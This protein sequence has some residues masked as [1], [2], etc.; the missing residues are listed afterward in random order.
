MDT[1]VPWDKVELRRSALKRDRI[2][3]VYLAM[4]SSAMVWLDESQIDGLL[5]YSTEKRKVKDQFRE[6]NT[7]T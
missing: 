1:L 6:C 7:K 3:V 4:Q 5:A 2:M